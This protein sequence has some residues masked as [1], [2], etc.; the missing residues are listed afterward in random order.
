[1][2]LL[3]KSN[4]SP[5]SRDPPTYPLYLPPP[6]LPYIRI[7]IRKKERRRGEDREEEI[8]FLLFFREEEPE[9]GRK[10]HRAVYGRS[11]HH[12][13]VVIAESRLRR[14]KRTS[15]PDSNTRWPGGLG[16]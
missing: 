1:L 7:R 10:L 5:I 15:P 11:L 16:T 13:R 4:K 6:P 9:G 2:S 12:G 3:V 8:L 14:L